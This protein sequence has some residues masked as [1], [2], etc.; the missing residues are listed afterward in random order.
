MKNN[1]IISGVPRAGKSTISHILSKKF[2]YQ[3]I[4]M[5][6]INAG[7][8]KAFPELGV[9]TSADMPSLEKLRNISSKIA[10]FIKAMMDSGEYDEFQPGMILDVYQL[11]PEDYMKYL[12]HANCEIFY[13]IPSEMTPEERFSI[14]KTYDTEKDYTF[15]TPEEELRERCVEIV[16][17]SKFIKEQCINYNLPYYETTQNR[18]EVFEQFIKCFEHNCSA[19]KREISTISCDKA[20]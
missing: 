4:S 10:P 13:F 2:G 18:E 14:L 7:L 8:E 20:F 15:Y 17:V 3:H 19:Q 9:N 12:H 6:S 16:E 11:L 5:D 1:I